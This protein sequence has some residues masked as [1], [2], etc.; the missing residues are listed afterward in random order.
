MIFPIQADFTSGELSPKL[1]ARY[2]LDQYITGSKTMLNFYCHA[3]GGFSNRAGTKFLANFVDT[4]YMLVPFVFSVSQAYLLVF[5]DLRMYVMKDD[6][7]VTLDLV[8]SGTYKWTQSPTTATE[9]Y[10]EL[11]AGGD[12]GIAEVFQL[13]EDSG[14]MTAGTVGSLTAGTWDW[15]DNDSLTYDTVYVRLTDSSDPDTKA[16]GFLQTPYYLV[17]PYAEADLSDIAY[18]QTADTMYVNHPDKALAKITRT[19]HDAWSVDYVVYD[20]EPWSPMMPEHRRTMMTVPLGSGTQT[21]RSTTSIFESYQIGSQLLMGFTNLVDPAQVSWA[22]G[23]ITAVA[24]STSATVDFGDENPGAQYINNPEFYQALDYWRDASQGTSEIE[25]YTGG[26]TADPLMNFVVGAVGTSNRAIAR[27]TVTLAKGYKHRISVDVADLTAGV[28]LMDV[29]VGTT[30]GA[31]D[32][33]SAV[34]VSAAGSYSYE[35]TNA[36]EEIFVEINMYSTTT[37]PASGRISRVSITMATDG[38]TSNWRIAAFNSENGYGRSIAFHDQ[39]LIQGG[40]GEFPQTVWQTRVG[41]YENFGFSTPSQSDDGLSHTMDSREVN[42]IEWLVST[43]ELIAGTTGGVW[44]LSGGSQSSVMTPTDIKI[45]SQSSYRCA[46]QRPVVIGDTVLFIE[47]GSTKIR[48]LNYSFEQDGYESDDLTKNSAH[49]FESKTIVDWAYARLPDSIVWCVLSDGTFVGMTYQ[50]EDKVFGW[51]RHDTAGLVERVEVVPGLVE[52][53][54]YFVVKRT[55]DGQDRRYVERL[56]NR[57]EDEDTYDYFFVDCGLSYN[58]TTTPITTVTGLDHLE[59]ETVKILA[60]GSVLPDQEVVDGSVTLTKASNVINIGLPYSQD[61]EG[62]DINLNA[63]DG[64]TQ[65]K[66]KNISQVSLRVYKTRGIWVGSSADDL[67]EMKM[68]NA[69]DGEDPI[70]LYTGEKNLEVDMDPSTGASVFIRNSDPIPVTI[71]SVVPEL[72]VSD[73]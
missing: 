26:G 8:L 14:L 65:L 73:E 49:L 53:V 24:S 10:L 51:H 55:I 71:L 12:P 56:M 44:V 52:D 63:E 25:L 7:V 28:T 4:E 64:S 43:R 46:R 61:W 31:S 27:Q 50:K 57:I 23:T 34:A 2:G 66:T 20:A 11:N 32:L 60:D 48:D 21:V 47:K 38:M 70:A 13:Y 58:S 41:D 15:G 33:V 67:Y 6:G 37:I 9:Y 39:R 59:G 3:E 18:V 17:T 16:D 1:H 72:D 30:E 40:C 45:R 68:R 22:A 5:T 54:T 62:L 29:Y 42:G 69:A 36:Q 19:G 35:F